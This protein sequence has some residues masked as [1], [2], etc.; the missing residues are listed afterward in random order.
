ML[1]ASFGYIQKMRS[2]KVKNPHQTFKFEDGRIFPSYRE[3]GTSKLI[4]YAR[5][6]G[7]NW[8][9]PG[10]RHKTWEA[11]EGGKNDERIIPGGD[12]ENG[13]FRNLQANIFVVLHAALAT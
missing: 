2:S 9:N 5:V 6:C 4:A 12:F 11:E 7:A 1:H 10:S 13:G 3:T 8:G